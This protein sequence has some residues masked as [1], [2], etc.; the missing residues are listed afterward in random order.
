MPDG[1]SKKRRSWIG[2]TITTLLGVGATIAVGWY[3]LSRT[4]AQAALAELERAR[5]VQ[6][7][8]VSILEEHVLN[9]KPIALARLARLI[10]QRRSAQN[11]SLPITLS[12]VIEE[13]E[14]NI[15]KSAY[16]PF[17]RKETLKVV[18]D[19]LYSD[20]SARQFVPYSP[21]APN[22]DLVNELAIRIQEGKTKEALES[23][24]RLQE[25]HVA[26][27]AYAST[28]RE[29]REF[30]DVVQELLNN[31]LP[32]LAVYLGMVVLLLST[33]RYRKIL[34]RMFGFE[35]RE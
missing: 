6:S 14:F 22:A 34:R 21:D 27:V 26:Q 12:D 16:L 10:D 5:G 1:E 19:T 28:R 11:I 23:L 33:P 25:A 35:E 13:A 29:K 20:L 15:L 7:S 31:P 18:F 17:D 24:T 4:E 3:Q 8:V 30:S 32:L 9:D 2:L